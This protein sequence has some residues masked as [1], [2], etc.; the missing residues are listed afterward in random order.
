VDVRGPHTRRVDGPVLA[1]LVGL[2]ASWLAFVA[3]L[4][5]LRPRDVR[6]RDLVRVVP[7][8]LRLIRD[9]LADGSIPLA[10]RL[11][12]LGLLAWLVSPIDL[13]PEFVPVL[14]PLDDV[15]VAVLVLRYVRRRLGEDALRDRWRG[16]EEGFGLLLGILDPGSAARHDRD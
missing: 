13:I 10:P 3:L 1:I 7:D 8:V 15:V 16:S 5:L 2:L 6:L 11:A 12:L 9:L 4:W 14:G